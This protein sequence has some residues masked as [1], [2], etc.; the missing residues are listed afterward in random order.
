MLE[1]M[2]AIRTLL[3]IPPAEDRRRSAG[4]SREE[5]LSARLLAVK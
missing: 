5:A 3:C 2:V 4:I 1:Q